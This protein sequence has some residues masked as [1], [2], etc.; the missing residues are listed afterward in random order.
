MVMGPSGVGKTSIAVGLAEAIGATFIEGDDY[1]PP[2]NRAAMASGHP[3][4]D[5]MRWPW[6][7]ALSVAVRDSIATQR[8]VFACS[9]LKRSYRDLL[10]DR[11]GGLDL[12]YLHAPA[13]LI[14][15]R[16]KA[17]VHFMPPELL[18]SQLDTL[19]VPTPDEEP[20]TLDMTLSIEGAVNQGLDQLRARHGL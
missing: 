15:E 14:L 1:H 4:T 2:E 12:V 19:E 7:E 17:R 18:Q 10:R 20:I 9:A 16:M 6:L 8:T 13:E 3:L 5:E 11:I